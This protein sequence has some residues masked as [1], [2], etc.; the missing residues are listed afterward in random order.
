LDL[1]IVSVSQNNN[2]SWY[3]ILGCGV[4]ANWMELGM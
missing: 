3:Y 1:R 4:S 2:D